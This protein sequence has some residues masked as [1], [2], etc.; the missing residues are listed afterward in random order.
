MCINK[1]TMSV[2]EKMLQSHKKYVYRYRKMFIMDCWIKTIV[3]Y[4]DH[5]PVCKYI[6]RD[7]CTF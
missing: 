5:D 3:Q 6:Y 7:K 4:E 1:S 2:Y